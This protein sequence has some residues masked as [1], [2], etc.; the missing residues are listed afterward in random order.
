MP[1][2]LDVLR[3]KL[4]SR[5]N[6]LDNGFDRHVVS[7]VAVRHVDK[8]A[9]QEGYVSALWQAWC[10][11]CRELIIHSSRG[12]ITSSGVGTT[13]P[14]NALGEMEIAYI[15][16]QLS[17]NAPITTIRPLAGSHQEHTWGDLSKVNLVAS[18]IGC[19]NHASI[20][21]GLSA[22]VRIQDLQLCRN[23]CA[24]ISRSTLQG[25]K[26][27]K[28]RYLDNSFKHPSDMIFW[29]DPSNLD[30]LWKSWIDEIKLASDFAIQ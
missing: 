1:L 30:F 5:L 17:N 13:S 4:Q 19:S 3:N 8:F 25:V 2:L 26:A 6:A 22:C 28:V 24:H 16:K 15:A 18:T 21:T 7:P 29:V 20:L 27:A 10:S 11:F 14:H 23:A 9:L 12:A